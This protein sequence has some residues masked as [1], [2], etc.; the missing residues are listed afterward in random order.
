M[1]VRDRSVDPTAV[2][3]Y[4]R[5][6]EL[7]WDESGPFWRLHG[8]NRFRAGYIRRQLVTHF[9][10][11]DSETRAPLDGLRL[12]DIGCGGGLLSEALARLGA[13][14]HGVDVVGRNMSQH[15]DRPRARG[16]RGRSCR[17]RDN[18]RQQRH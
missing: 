10:L 2:A 3:H 7:W 4:R 6:A 5:L 17:L 1:S 8:L 14:V 13:S 18:S 9:G 11:S 12:L 16:V 15:R